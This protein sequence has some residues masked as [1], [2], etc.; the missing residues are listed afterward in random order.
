MS[1][2]WPFF[3][4]I[5]TSKTAPSP[6]LKLGISSEL[7]FIIPFVYPYPPLVTLTEEIFPEEETTIETTASSPSPL[8]GIFV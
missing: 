1:L 5:I 3:G 4:G 7:K 2:P 8:I 6:E